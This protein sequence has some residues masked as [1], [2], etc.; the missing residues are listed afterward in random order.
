[1]SKLQVAIQRLQFGDEVGAE[2]VAS[3]L[4]EDSGRNFCDV[5]SEVPDSCV[6]ISRDVWYSH[7]IKS[8]LFMSSELLDSLTLNFQ[9][10]IYKDNTRFFH[11]T[12]Y[13]DNRQCNI[14]IVLAKNKNDQIK[15]ILNEFFWRLSRS[16]H[17]VYQLCYPLFR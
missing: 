3:A 7:S 17:A 14:Y 6:E 11:P 13:K 15:A 4:N 1:M 12:L 8:Y 9:P 16:Y 5:V 2:E 10:T